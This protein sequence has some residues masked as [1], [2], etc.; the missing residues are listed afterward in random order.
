MNEEIIFT[1]L[2][3]L[4]ERHEEK[5]CG[6]IKYVPDARLNLT[7]FGDLSAE[8]KKGNFSDAFIIL[9][10]NSEGKKITLFNCRHA[11]VQTAN[12]QNT[13]Y[14][15][16]E[17]MFIGQHFENEDLIKFI[18]ISIRFEHL[19]NWL[20]VPKNTFDRITT[21]QPEQLVF[22]LKAFDLIFY[23]ITSTEMYKCETRPF[24]EIAWTI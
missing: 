22:H 4:P 18:D 5:T 19:E 9:G 14:Y 10:I 23:W 24:V 17:W 12:K 13:N 11:K 1:G 16:I 2:W 21:N 20:P 7:L 6:T 3:W 15:Q 8:V